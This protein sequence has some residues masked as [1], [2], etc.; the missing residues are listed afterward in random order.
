M[1]KKQTKKGKSVLTFS[2]ILYF[3][4]VLFVSIM[5]SFTGVSLLA[6]FEKIPM[7]VEGR[8][9]PRY[10]LIFMSLGSLTMGIVMIWISSHML[11]KHINRIIVQMNRLSCGDFKARLNFPKPLSR[12]PTFREIESSFNLMAEELEHTEVLRSDFI[13]NFSHEFKTPIVSIA[14]FAKLLKYGNLTE[15]QRIEYLSVIEEESLRLS[16]MATNVLNM[17]KVENQMILTD[18]SDF[19][20]SEQIRASV[21]L[22]EKSWTKKKIEFNLAFEEYEIKANEELLKQVWIN[23]LDN[24]IKFSPEYGLITVKIT[25]RGE[26]YKIAVSNSGCEIPKEKRR[27]IFDKFYQ[28]DESHS[29][30]G[31]GIGLAIVKKV[32][33]LHGGEVFAE[34]E[35]EITTFYVTLPKKPVQAEA[36]CLV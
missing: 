30:E 23:L 16:V 10:V 29:S 20:L 35:N 18:L 27:K 4:T 9:S 12:H 31:N 11:S 7:T 21:L 33:E 34:C 3:F 5:V 14:G 13:N 8:P 24:A 1:N 28:I 2:A 32:V 26:A 6:S 19:N 17:S 36:D 15:E 22:L 25:E